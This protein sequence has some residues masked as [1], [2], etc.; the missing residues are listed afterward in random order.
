MTTVSAT[1]MEW[2]LVE[3]LRRS[4]RFKSSY[5]YT[6]RSR[7]LPDE[8]DLHKEGKTGGE[9]KLHRYVTSV[10]LFVFHR[11][12]C[13]EPGQEKILLWKAEFLAGEA[14][15]TITCPASCFNGPALTKK[16]CIFVNLATSVSFD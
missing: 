11:L 7:R 13:S 1:Q 10:L 9:K 14:R 16:G 3:K 6:C 4:F 12:L 15:K 8:E 5:V 2:G